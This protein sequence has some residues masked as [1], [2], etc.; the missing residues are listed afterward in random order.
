MTLSAPGVSDLSRR[1]KNGAWSTIGAA[2][3]FY[4]PPGGVKPPATN[5]AKL[6]ARSAFCLSELTLRRGQRGLSLEQR[7][8]AL[9]TPAIVR[10]LAVGPH[11][12][13][14]RNRH[15]QR[16]GSTGLLHLD[17]RIGGANL[18]RKRGV[19][20]RRAGRHVLQR[21]PDTHLELSAANVE[22][23]FSPLLRTLDQFHDL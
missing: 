11:G 4:R 6:P 16:I 1:S 20:H 18:F 9:N 10:Q 3:L 22:G 12:A 5:A 7:A 14:A 2:P 19:A 15:G 23:Q 17:L 21:L 8:L 13:V